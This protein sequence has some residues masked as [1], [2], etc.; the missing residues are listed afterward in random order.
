MHINCLQKKFKCKLQVQ[1]YELGVK[2]TS[3]N[4]QGTSSN[5]GVSSSNTR[6]TGSHL[7]VT[8]S[9]LQVRSLKTRPKRLKAQAA[10]LKTW[11]GILKNELNSKLP[12]KKIAKSVTDIAK[13]QQ[14]DYN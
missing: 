13:N 12:L 5:L 2:I 9:N 8:G 6:V 1:T 10:R 14:K 11:V 4:P 7:R 3:S